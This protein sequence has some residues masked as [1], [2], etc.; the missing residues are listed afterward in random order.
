MVS[1]A[2][3]PQ[4]QFFKLARGFFLGALN[5]LAAMFLA[6]C[7]S[8]VTAEGY[9]HVHKSQVALTEMRRCVT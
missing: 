9:L 5:Y 8:Q 2:T 3:Y 6:H 4:I 1:P 7:K